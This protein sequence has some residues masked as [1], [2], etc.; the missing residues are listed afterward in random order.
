MRRQ[1]F[2]TTTETNAV[3]VLLLLYVFATA[4][5]AGVTLNMARISIFLLLG[6]SYFEK[7]TN[8]NI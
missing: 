5:P 6:S 4:M 3:P 7:T 8:R 2:H 1:T